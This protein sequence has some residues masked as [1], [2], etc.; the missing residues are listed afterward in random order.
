[1]ALGWVAAIVLLLA[2]R[3]APVVLVAAAL[4]LIGGLMVRFVIVSLPEKL[5][6]G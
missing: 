1:V 6:P 5:G 2:W 3:S 4:I